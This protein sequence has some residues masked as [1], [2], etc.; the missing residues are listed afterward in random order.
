MKLIIISTILVAVVLAVFPV[1][2]VNADVNS[3]EEV[4]KASA[5]IQVPLLVDGIE[6]D[7]SVQSVP[8]GSNVC[9]STAIKY[10]R[11]NERQRFSIWEYQASTSSTGSGVRNL[12]QANQAM[13]NE[14][15]VMTQSGAYIAK[16]IQEVLFQVRSGLDA[17][18]Q[19]RW[20]ERDTIVE[21][22]VPELVQDSENVRYKFSGWN[23]GESPFTPVN[24][25]AILAPTVL[26]LGW[27]VEYNM[28]VEDVDGS[29]SPVSGWY[30]SNDTVVIRAPEEILK[31]GGREKLTFQRWE[32][33][34][35]PIPKNYKNPN[36]AILV[37]G[38]CLLRPIYAE[39]F[40]VEANSFR[41]VLFQKWVQRG[42]EV[43]I[44]AP[45]L[46]KV[47]PER[48]QY[49]F[50]GWEGKEGLEGNELK[51]TI[52]SPLSLEAVYQRQFKLNVRS[53]YGASGDGWYNDG[54]KA[55]VMAPQ[56][57]QSMLF[58]KRA[59]D[60]FLG[61]GNGGYG[62]DSSL[63]ENPVTTVQ[64]NEPMTIT[65]AYRSEINPKVLFVIL[66]VL[67]VG[68]LAY[69][70]TEWGPGVYR[71]L[72]PKGVKVPVL[73]EGHAQLEQKIIELEALNRLV[74][75]QMTEH[76]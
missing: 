33:V 70:G 43:E 13:A 23:G 26:E 46:I 76:D 36:M 64:V 35:G 62:D 75:R 25:I 54:H 14:C 15:I 53:P 69:L 59:F 39:S 2:A 29:L 3:G 63:S 21:L 51:L 10:T 58:F 71:R 52:G 30:R 28:K 74:Q 60:G 16:Y 20:V 34:Y 18:K 49:V 41:G 47:S 22:S 38:P 19:S 40:L 42:H 48:E 12:A 32:V 27:T 61:I 55:I 45:A 65:A 56:E 8:I 57:P 68:T 73:S 9:I 17:Y 6:T 37:D 7:G 44:K 67:A 66:G 11:V 5:N 1:I 31:D 4:T 24:R 50:G 72:R